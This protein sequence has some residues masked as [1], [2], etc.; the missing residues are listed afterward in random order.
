MDRHTIHVESMEISS[1]TSYVP[2]KCFLFMGNKIL[3]MSEYKYSVLARM[4]TEPFLFFLD[5]DTG[6]TR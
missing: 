2:L 4:N 5:V 6:Y 1:F 3:K